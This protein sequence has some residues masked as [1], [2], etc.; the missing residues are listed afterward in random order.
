MR[1]KASPQSAIFS[2]DPARETCSWSCGPQ[3]WGWIDDK[4]ETSAIEQKITIFA[5]GE[6]CRHFSFVTGFDLHAS[7]ITMDVTFA[8]V[9][10]MPIQ[11]QCSSRR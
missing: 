8:Q 3:D 6:R 4:G 11:T 9:A 2:A 1:R 5:A 7:P 10:F